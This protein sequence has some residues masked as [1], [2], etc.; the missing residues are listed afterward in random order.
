MVS[1]L[2][3]S[4]RWCRNHCSKECL[5]LTIALCNAVVSVF[6][7]SFIFFRGFT[8]VILMLALHYTTAHIWVPYSKNYMDR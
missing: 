1:P 7:S 6:L 8:I 5:L 2:L 3:L 4:S